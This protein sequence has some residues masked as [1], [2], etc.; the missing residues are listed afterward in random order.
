MEI[1]S[2]KHLERFRSIYLPDK[3][4]KPPS[5]GN[6]WNM[7]TPCAGHKPTLKDQKVYQK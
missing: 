3:Y 4:S 6:Y 5:G 2:L 1:N 7:T